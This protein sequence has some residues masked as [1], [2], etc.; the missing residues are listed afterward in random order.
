MSIRCP[1][2]MIQYRSRHLPFKAHSIDSTT[3]F[4]ILYLTTFWTSNSRFLFDSLTSTVNRNARNTIFM[5]H[6]LADRSLAYFQILKYL[7]HSVFSRRRNKQLQPASLI[8]EQLSKWIMLKTP[9]LSTLWSRFSTV[10]AYA[11]VVVAL[12]FTL[13]CCSF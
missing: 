3:N 4:N 1:A 13:V 11:E 9:P 8:L 2:H 12:G 5:L 7:K 6:Q 10:A